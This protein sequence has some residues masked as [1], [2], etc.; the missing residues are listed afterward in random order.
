MPL[1]CSALAS[2]AHLWHDL[3]SNKKVVVLLLIQHVKDY[4]HEYDFL[5]ASIH[6]RRKTLSKTSTTCSSGVGRVNWLAFEYGWFQIKYH[7]TTGCGNKKLTTFYGGLRPTT[8]MTQ[9]PFLSLY[10]SPPVYIL[11]HKHI[12]HRIPNITRL[13]FQI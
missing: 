1:R 9:R 4:G 10:V 6:M 13:T 3:D 2:F 5:L 11:L 7:N 12:A 8:R